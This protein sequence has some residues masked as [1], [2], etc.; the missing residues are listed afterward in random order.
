[1]G[2]LLSHCRPLE[3]PAISTLGFL[4][5]YPSRSTKDAATRE[6]V[7]GLR[8]G[9]LTLERA[10][11]LLKGGADATK[12]I[13][14]GVVA[15]GFYDLHGRDYSLVQLAIEH[16]RTADSLDIIRLLLDRGADINFKGYLFGPPVE[17]AVQ[18]GRY[19][20][21]HML[22][23]DPKVDIKA[24]G[25][26]LWRVASDARDGSVS[27]AEKLRM[28]KRLV[29]MGGRAAILF[30]TPPYELPHRDCQHP[31]ALHSFC[32]HPL[33]HL[34]AQL[35]LMAYLIHKAG[36]YIVRIAEPSTDRTPLS[37]AAR[38]DFTDPSALRL[39]LRNGASLRGVWPASEHS[40]RRF[41]G[42]E[43]LAKWKR[44]RLRDAYCDYLRYDLPV[45]VSIA[46]KTALLPARALTRTAL[47]DGVIESIEALIDEDGAGGPP[48][49]SLHLDIIGEDPFGSRIN[50]LANSYLST[51]YRN[52]RGTANNK[53]VSSKEWM[54][55]RY[56]VLMRRVREAAKEEERRFGPM[57]SAPLVLRNREK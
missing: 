40:S 41:S 56:D 24:A 53:G 7:D 43:L 45:Q 47:P 30:N 31:T 23:D 4:D 38:A 57:K 6:L 25:P 46:V 18:R 9:T 55:H 5:I 8:N 54:R 39:L 20:V 37:Y 2:G 13:A 22:L 11:Q 12:I 52:I 21:A 27:S 49:V 1:M 19:D 32:A 17:L 44:A 16:H 3:P 42:V 50:E 48:A 35:H 34:P 28:A 33:D 26:L 14:S 29:R 10:T 15:E 36:R 51:A